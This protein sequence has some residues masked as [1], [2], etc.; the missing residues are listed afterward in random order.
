MIRNNQ[1]KYFS[2]LLI[3]KYRF[4]ENKFIVE[5]E[6]SVLE[7]LSSKF[8]CEAI[9]IS[10]DFFKR[11]KGLID[12]LKIAPDK[13]HI[14]KSNEFNKI[15]DTKSP[16]GIA[17]VFKDRN[18]NL[19]NI[20]DNN[21]KII[22]MLDN[23]S[24]PGNLGTTIRTCDWFGIK[25][26]VLSGESVDWTNPKVLRSTMGSIFRV[27]IFQIN[28]YEELENLKSNGYEILCAD[29]DGDNIFSFKTDKNKV[30]IFSNEAHGP[31]EEIFR[32]V[33]KK[34]TIPKIGE[35]DSLNVASASAV[36]LAELT[37]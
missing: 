33:D 14:L 34:I 7:G 23:I 3:K 31:S 13:I 28:N 1:L 5:G 36:I 19:N 18:L 15:S 29:T 12:S 30:V 25:N 16:Q 9:L 2:S 35:A 4:K 8:N 20:S 11:K 22:V 6:R 26:I 10:N 32:H 24:D 27:N 21:G 17:A 37:K